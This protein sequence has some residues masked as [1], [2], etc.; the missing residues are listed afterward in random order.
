V[1]ENPELR[2]DTTK[3]TAEQAADAIIARLIP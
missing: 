3:M 1:P 2:I